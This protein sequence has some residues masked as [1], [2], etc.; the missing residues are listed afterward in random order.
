[1]ILI[2]HSQHCLQLSPFDSWIT[3]SFS[4]PFAG[5]LAILSPPFRDCLQSWPSFPGLFALSPAFAGLTAIFDIL[6]QSACIPSP[7]FAGL[8]AVLAPFHW[9]AIRLSPPFARLHNVFTNTLPGTSLTTLLQVCFAS[10]TFVT[11][12]NALHAR[13]HNPTLHCCSVVT[14]SCR[15]FCSFSLHSTDAAYLSRHL[16]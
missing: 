6:R 10:C 3:C 15:I 14:S 9:T 8:F 2:F 5:L 13:Q 1:M 4:P 12:S 16:L 11:Y 7:P